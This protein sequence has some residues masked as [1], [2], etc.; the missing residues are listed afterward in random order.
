MSGVGARQLIVWEGGVPVVRNVPL[1]TPAQIKDLHAAALTQI[2]VEPDDHLKLEMGL[3]PSRFYGL[4]LL[5]VMLI[6]RAER[7]AAS[8]DKDEVESILDRE[9]GKPK[10]TAEVHSTTETYEQ[11]LKR[12]GKEEEERR[13]K[14]A[15]PIEA[16]IADA[17]VVGEAWEHL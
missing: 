3:P 15:K 7:A 6:R 12:I 5:E 4:T 17:E 8:G 11:M 2:Y 16:E 14:A 1:V 9:L 10:T 13:I